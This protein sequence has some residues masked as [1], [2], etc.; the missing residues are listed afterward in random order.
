[1]ISV[2]VAGPTSIHTY[3]AAPNDIRGM[4]G[5]LQTECV[6]MNGRGGFITKGISNLVDYVTSSTAS[7]RLLNS[8]RKLTSDSSAKSPPKE[9][10]VT[11]LPS[12]DLSHFAYSP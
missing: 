9:F 11:L 6:A 8:Y 5:W 3:V 10:T 4:A 7:V 2:E 12:S 1:M